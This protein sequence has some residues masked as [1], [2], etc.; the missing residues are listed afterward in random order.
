MNLRKTITEGI[1]L[2]VLSYCLP[3]FGGCDK[4]E[5]ESIQVMQNK[6]ARLVTHLPLRTPRTEIFKQIGW[7]TVSQLIFYH[8]ALS[9]FRIRQSGEPEYLSSIMNRNNLTGRIIVSNTT[10]TLAKNS[11]CFRGSAQWNS[12][13]E[14]IRKIRKISQFKVQLKKWIFM[15]V[16]QFT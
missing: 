4:A 6:A 7:L 2:S 1:F 9:T 12:L 10:L 5:I 15:N 8:T 13:P 3:L 16:A 14:H 11:F